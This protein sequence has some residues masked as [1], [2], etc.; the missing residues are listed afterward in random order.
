MK[1]LHKIQTSNYTDNYTDEQL[2][3]IWYIEINMSKS[4][5]YTFI[6]GYPHYKQKE[7]FELRAFTPGDI[8]ACMRYWARAG[9]PRHIRITKMI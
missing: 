2:S 5:R 7:G 6:D 4:V 8:D 9:S 3:C 1:N